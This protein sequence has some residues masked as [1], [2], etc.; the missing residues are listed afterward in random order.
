M[1]S[2]TIST[3]TSAG[4]RLSE[5]LTHAREHSDALFQVLRP[6]AIYERG[7]PERHRFIFYLGHL[8]AFDWNL[9]GIKTLKLPAFRAE[10]DKLFAFGID[11]DGGHLPSDKAED[12]P[13]EADVR[14]YCAETRRRIDEAFADLD[15][16][17]VHVAI[18]HRLMHLE[19]L[20]YLLHNLEPRFKLG[21]D[22]QAET[23]GR[24]SPNE[25]IPVQGGVVTLGQQPGNFGWDNEF[26]LRTRTV[27]PFLIQKHKVT[28]GDYLRFVEE[29]AAAPHFWV[30]RD[31][32]WFLRRMFSEIPLPLDWPVWTTHFEAAAYAAHHGYRLPTE[33]QFHRAAFGTPGGEERAYPWGD[34]GP[35]PARGNFDFYRWNPC[36]VDANPAGDS[37]FGVA[38]LVGNGWEWTSTLFERYDGFTPAPFYPG[39]SANF[40]DGKHWVLKGASPRTALPLLRRSFR[41]WFRGDYR[42]AFTGF[43]CISSHV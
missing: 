29:G 24:A 25:F 34:E 13:A 12:W 22:E 9:L 39:Y 5:Q 10:W 4:A 14:G 17:R 16:E 41:N 8:E 43:R 15:S 6:G 28:N 32:V 42:Y 30:R 19:T 18:E 40:F 27:A 7:V 23:S 33:E 37:A 36:P 35:S 1:P 3:L 2:S 31:G 26:P 11:P 38:Q 21:K 20:A